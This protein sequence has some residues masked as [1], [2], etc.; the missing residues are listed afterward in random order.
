MKNDT[1]RYYRDKETFFLRGTCHLSLGK[2][3]HVKKED[4]IFIHSGQKYPFP[5]GTGLF[6]SV[7]IQYLCIFKAPKSTL[8]I[9]ASKEEVQIIYHNHKPLSDADMHT[10]ADLI[11]NTL[12]LDLHYQKQ[13]SM[14]VIVSYSLSECDNDIISEPGFIQD[15]II[16]GVRRAEQHIQN[17]PSF[18]I[19]IP[20]EGE[21]KKESPKGK[22]HE[23]IPENCPYYPC[24]DIANQICDYCYCP[25]YPCYD[26]ELGTCITSSKGEM[27]WSCE[28]CTL[29]HYPPIAAH[30]KIYPVASLAELKEV[31]AEHADE[32]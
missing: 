4:T 25:F 29:L 26:E 24:H 16:H 28:A 1:I 32:C 23:W 5:K 10:I 20:R 30:L 14:N 7:P 21:S 12:V 2:D 15:I 27:V 3:T 6:T 9:T 31:H 22:W 11:D 19:F 13:S 18:Q 8:F 17:R